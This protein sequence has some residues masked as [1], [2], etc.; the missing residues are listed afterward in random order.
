MEKS[1]A[2]EIPNLR[3]SPLAAVLTH[4]VWIIHGL[5]FDELRGKK[6]GLNGDTGHD[7]VP[8]SSLCAHALPKFL[9]NSW[10]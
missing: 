6:G 9:T 7:T 3:V 5:W 4:K 2:H 1:A 10:H 8:Q